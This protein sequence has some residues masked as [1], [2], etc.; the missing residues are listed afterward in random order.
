MVKADN[1][2]YRLFFV[3]AHSNKHSRINVLQQ[4]IR[5]LN[6]ICEKAFLI[7]KLLI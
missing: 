4:F 7:E 5:Y 3:I 1:A 6:Y 2:S